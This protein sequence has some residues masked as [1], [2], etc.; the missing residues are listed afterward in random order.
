MSDTT[1]ELACVE[2][3]EGVDDDATAEAAYADESTAGLSR[4]A[5]LRTA[6]DEAGLALVWFIMVLIVLLGFAA[7]AVDIGHGYLVAQKAQ[8]AADAAA[9]AGTVYL[10]QDAASATSTA[11]SVAASNGFANGVNSVTVTA[12]QQPEPTQLKVTVKQSVPTWFARVLGF[13]SMNISRSATASYDQPVAM[14]SPANTFGN[15][16]DCSIPCTSGNATPQ[17]WAN[18]AGSLSPKGNGDQYQ[19]NFCAGG[20]DNCPNG[21]TNADYSS[22]GYVYA[23]NNASANSQLKIDIFDPAFFNVGDHCDASNTPGVAVA[24]QASEQP[25]SGLY[26]AS[27]N[28]ARYATGDGSGYCSGDQYFAPQSGQPQVLSPVWTSYVVYAPDSTPWT[29]ADNSVVC[30]MDFPGYVDRPRCDV[31]VG[32]R[33]L[34]RCQRPAAQLVPEMGERLHDRERAGG[35]VLRAGTHERQGQWQRGTGG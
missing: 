32:R 20:F 27:G 35:F 16:P 7:L 26:T 31:D 15:Q 30:S 23:V 12:T 17:F 11:Q 34:R 33:Q 21:G 14:G 9:L 29:L 2:D 28:N 1:P 22:N 6:R 5:R 10:P 8:N 25:R 3:I 13:K 19:A 18:V 24:A 4:F